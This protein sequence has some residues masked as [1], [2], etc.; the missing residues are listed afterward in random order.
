MAVV[1]IT[2]AFSAKQL[3]KQNALVRRIRSIE[4]LGMSTVIC[5][6]KTGTLTQNKMTVTQLRTTDALSQKDHNSI[7]T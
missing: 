1:T 4:S 7:S 6:D 2:L 3:F 5:T